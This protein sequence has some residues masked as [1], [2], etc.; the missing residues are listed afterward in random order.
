MKHTITFLL[1]SLF[2]LSAI[3]AEA[4]TVDPNFGT[5]GFAITD[6]A[7]DADIFGTMANLP[8]GKIVLFGSSRISGIGQFG[9]SNT[10]GTNQP[11]VLAMVKYNSDGSLDSSFGLNGKVYY[12]VDTYQNFT[13]SCSVAQSDGKV[14]VG[15]RSNGLQAERAIL[16]RFLPDGRLDPSFGVNGSIALEAQNIYDLFLD[17]NNK[18]I[19]VGEKNQDGCIE[20]LN[21]NGFFDPNFGTLGVTLVDDN[22]SRL[23]IRKGKALSDGSILCFGESSNNGFAD[24]VVFLKFS[25]TGSY[26]SAFGIKRIT[27]GQYEN[28]YDMIQFEILPDS[29]ML[30]LTGGAYYNSNFTNFGYARFYKIDLNGVPDPSFSNPLFFETYRGFIKILN[31]Q[32]ILITCN[33]DTGAVRNTILTPSGGLVSQSAPV[34]GV[35]S[36]AVTFFG[37]YQYIGYNDADYR[38]NGYILD[39]SLSTNDLSNLTCVLSPNPVKDFVT[40]SID[41]QTDDDSRIEVYSLTGA[42]IKVYE[43]KTYENGRQIFVENLSNFASGL[44]FFKIKSGTR[45]KTVKVIK[46]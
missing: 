22:G 12:S 30:V 2:V 23:I 7:S 4:Q 33:T 18:I 19:A 27:N 26:D 8:D 36:F 28:D 15:G 21:T 11:Y 34:S 44:Y 32:N 20:R 37:N 43:P 14:I 41:T 35:G 3:T 10:D 31:N 25:T 29:S 40:V 38:I 17:A 9:Y 24:N 1:F 45:T 16:L 46:D 39:T 5:N 6:F 13:P 42:L